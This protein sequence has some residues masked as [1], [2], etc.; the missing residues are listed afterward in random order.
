M[1]QDIKV[2][3]DKPIRYVID[4]HYHYDHAHGNQVFGPEV[5]VIGH[6]NTRKRM[7]GNVLEQYTYLTSVDPVARDDAQAAHRRSHG[8]R[9]RRRRSNATS[10]ISSRISRP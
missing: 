3:T 4:S 6:E 7:L 8:R 1:V 2:I 5:Q 10:P 9:S